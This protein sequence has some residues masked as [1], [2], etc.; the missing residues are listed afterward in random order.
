MV[1][2]KIFAASSS[3][4]ISTLWHSQP[5]VYL[6]LLKTSRS[7]GELNFFFKVISMLF[8]VENHLQ[9]LLAMFIK[10]PGKKSPLPILKHQKPLLLLTGFYI[11]LLKKVKSKNYSKFSNYETLFQFLSTILPHFYSWTTKVA[12]TFISC[13]PCFC[14]YSWVCKKHHDRLTQAVSQENLGKGWV[15]LSLF[16]LLFSVQS[17]N[18]FLWE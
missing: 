17:L 5:K 10:S 12:I 18:L 7:Q 13:K 3:H 11:Q 8:T 2:D 6:I 16:K 4:T 9:S 15:Q 1:A 14:V